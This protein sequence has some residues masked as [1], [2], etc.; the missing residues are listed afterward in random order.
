MSKSIQHIIVGATITSTLMVAA[1][2]ATPDALEWM[3]F[4]GMWAGLCAVAFGTATFGVVYLAMLTPN[5][6]IDSLHGASLK[7][8]AAITVVLGGIASAISFGIGSMYDESEIHT[9]AA[10]MW[11]S[12]TYL[13]GVSVVRL[14]L[15]L[16]R[17]ERGAAV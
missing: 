13:C 4:F 11:G 5:P 9:A 2:L 10:C 6:R 15:M 17:V 12:A 7:Q 3:V 16:R 8:D 14:Y 1:L